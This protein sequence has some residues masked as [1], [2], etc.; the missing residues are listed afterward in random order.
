MTAPAARQM[1][2]RWRI[3]EAHPQIAATSA[4]GRPDILKAKRRHS[5]TAC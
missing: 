4:S 5:S 2:D 1:N 3:V